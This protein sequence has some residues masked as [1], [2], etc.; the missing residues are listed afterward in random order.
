MERRKRTTYG[1]DRYPDLNGYI[2]RR[3]VLAGLGALAGAA[4]LPMATGGCIVTMPGLI[5]EDPDTYYVYLPVAGESRTLYFSYQGYV[6]YHVELR[7][8]TL[9][10]AEFLADNR[11]ALLE[12]IDEEMASYGLWTFHPD[13]DHS[14]VELTLT[15]LLADAFAGVEDALTNQFHFVDLVIDHYN[16]E[17]EVDG[18]LA[19]AS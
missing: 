15:Q 4:A 3:A 18:D 17:E 19:A 6:D 12:A 13:Q 1:D 7:V 9:E 16:E 2:D 11:D 5:A 8:E 10:L 14:G